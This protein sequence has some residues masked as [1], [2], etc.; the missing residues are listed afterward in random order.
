MGQSGDGWYQQL[1]LVE[2]RAETLLETPLCPLEREYTYTP[3]TH[4]CLDSAA[5]EICF[6]FYCEMST[7]PQNVG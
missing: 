4:W 5:N 3:S 7:Y 2:E 6:Y 1:E